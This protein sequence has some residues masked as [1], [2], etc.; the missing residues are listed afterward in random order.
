MLVIASTKA[1]SVHTL[2]LAALEKVF[3]PRLLPQGWHHEQEVVWA[4]HGSEVPNEL[5]LRLLWQWLQV[6][7]SLSILQQLGFSAL[8]EA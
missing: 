8:P 6:L 1:I 5:W 7:P 3:F 2:S 4:P